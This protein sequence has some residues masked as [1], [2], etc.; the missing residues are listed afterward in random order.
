KA[1]FGS[2]AA[3]SDINMT[4]PFDFLSAS[5][6][7]IARRLAPCSF[8]SVPARLIRHLEQIN[9]W[10]GPRDI[11]QGVDPAEAIKRFVN[12]CSG[13]FDFAQIEIANEWLRSSS[14]Y[15][16]RHLF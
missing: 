13:R 14:L 6:A 2:R 4:D 16:F 8:S 5:H 12:E 9:L 1:S 11:Q 7:S 10:H 15:S 3:L